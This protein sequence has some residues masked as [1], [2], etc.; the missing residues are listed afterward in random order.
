MEEARNF[1][2]INGGGLVAETPQQGGK[3]VFEVGESDD[4]LSHVV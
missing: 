2:V 4:N 1:P 3:G